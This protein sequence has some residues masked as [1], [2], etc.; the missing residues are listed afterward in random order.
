MHEPLSFT[1]IELL[2]IMIH[3]IGVILGGGGGA[4][5]RPPHFCLVLLLFTTKVICIVI[6]IITR[7][8]CTNNPISHVQNRKHV[9]YHKIWVYK[10]FCNNVQNVPGWISDSGYVDIYNFPKVILC[11]SVRWNSVTPQATYDVQLTPMIHTAWL[12]WFHACN[13]AY[14][15][16]YYWQIIWFSVV[17]FWCLHD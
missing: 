6:M 12:M 5:A 11:P 3:T 7:F 9:K 13:E 14:D 10:Y 8:K 1:S 17:S 4:Q 2:T 16:I 15:M